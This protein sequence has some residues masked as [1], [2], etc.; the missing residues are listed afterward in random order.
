MA[1]D[2]QE[3]GISIFYGYVLGRCCAARS[4]CAQ[5]SRKLLRAAISTAEHRPEQQLDP[6]K[7]LWMLLG[8][9]TDRVYERFQQLN[10]RIDHIHYSRRCALGAPGRIVVDCGVYKCCH[11]SARA[12]TARKP[13]G[14]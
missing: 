13:T 4:G 11:V 5:S 12:A 10:A 2:E 7:V 6:M 14:A 9:C 3:Q 1:Q 8:T